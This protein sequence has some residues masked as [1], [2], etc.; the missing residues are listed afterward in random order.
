MADDILLR[1]QIFG[2]RAMPVLGHPLYS[3]IMFVLSTPDCRILVVGSET[4]TLT[5]ASESR[6]MS[7]GA[8][9]RTLAVLKCEDDI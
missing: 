8:E 4:R 1:E 5:V 2:F 7:I 9:S 6:T 3:T